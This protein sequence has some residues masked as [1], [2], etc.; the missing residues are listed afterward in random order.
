MLRVS[1]CLDSGT[2]CRPP[3][4]QS[5]NTRDDESLSMVHL[6]SRG[7]GANSVRISMA[8]E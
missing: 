6:P 1:A 5:I 2:Y 8:L 7:G 3:V 4:E